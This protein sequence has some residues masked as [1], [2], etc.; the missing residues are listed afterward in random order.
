MNLSQSSFLRTTRDFPRNLDLMS[1][2]INKAYIDIASSVNERVIG[3]FPLNKTVNTG[4][5]YYLRGAN[6]QQTLRRVF[7][8]TTTASITHGLDLTTIPGFSKGYGAFTDGTNWYGLLFGSN[9]A[10]VGQR[11]FYISPTQIV[12]LAGA[13]APALTNG[14]LVIEWISNT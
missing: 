7:A 14:T 8:F 6:G 12:F 10:I 2:E 11:S 4:E 13:G 5:T 3:S 1:V 9:V